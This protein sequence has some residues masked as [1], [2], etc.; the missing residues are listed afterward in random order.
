[1]ARRHPVL[2]R[3]PHGF[4]RIA[5]AEESPGRGKQDEGSKGLEVHSGWCRFSLRALDGRSK[6]ISPRPARGRLLLRDTMQR[7][8]PP[9]Q[10]EAVDG[11]H[12]PARKTGSQHVG[13][14]GVLSGLPERGH[15]YCAVNDQEIRV[16]CRQLL[17]AVETRRGHRQGNDGELAAAGRAQ[18]VQPL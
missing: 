3:V 13:G 18:T 6:L 4:K 14:L 1:V 5:T 17:G 11:D 12:L 9:D 7:T 8:Q 15:Q 10:F 2:D 16:A